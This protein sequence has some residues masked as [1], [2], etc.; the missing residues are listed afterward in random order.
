ME[1]KWI[2]AG[3]FQ[4]RPSYHAED[5]AIGP[6]STANMA[7][8]Q[9]FGSREEACRSSGFTHWSS[10]KLPVPAPPQPEQGAE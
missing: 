8:A 4:G 2:L 3:T 9:R 6:R 7:E 5:H 10:N 1:G